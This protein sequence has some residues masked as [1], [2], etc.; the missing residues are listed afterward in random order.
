MNAELTLSAGGDE[1]LLGGGAAGTG[2]DDGTGAGEAKSSKSPKRSLEGGL[3]DEEDLGGGGGDCA[4]AKSR[5]LDGALTGAGGDFGCTEAA[6]GAVSKKLPPLKGGGDVT[7]GAE[8]ADLVEMLGARLPRPEN[9]D[10]CFGCGG[11]DAWDGKLRPLKALVRPPKA[12]VCGG[13]DDC[14]GDDRPPNEGCLL[15]GEESG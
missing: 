3:A 4:K 5:P 14:G 15:W 1:T 11:G 9:G 2:A 12:S 6:D 10:W 13:G 7:L 8:G